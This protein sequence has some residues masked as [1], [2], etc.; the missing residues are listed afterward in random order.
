MKSAHK[1]LSVPASDRGTFDAMIIAELDKVRSC[2]ILPLQP[3]L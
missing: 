3:I 1:T 2:L